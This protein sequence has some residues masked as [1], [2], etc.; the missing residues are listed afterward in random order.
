MNY[1][2]K[3]ISRLILCLMVLC[4][5]LP[6]RALAANAPDLS[7]K[8]DLTI[9][10]QYDTCPLTGAEFALWQVGELSG[11]GTLTLTG[12]YAHYPVDLN[13]LTAAQLNDAAATLYSYISLD[14]LPPQYTVATGEDGTV[15][16]ADIPWGV[17]LMYTPPIEDEEARL[18]YVTQPQLVILPHN[19]GSGW[20]Y[21][22]TVLPKCSPEPIEEVVELKVLKVWEDNNN[23][24]RPTSV[25]VHLLCDGAVYD[26]VTLSPEN[27]WRHSWEKLSAGRVWSVA[28]EVP[29]DYSVSITVEGNTFVVTNTGD[30]PPTPPPDIPQ[31]GLTWW[32]VPVLAF[33]GLVLIA[34]G[35]LVGRRR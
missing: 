14:S 23:P 4:L 15:M 11:E 30:Q 31:T 20:D 7:R 25:V 2:R 24:N 8:C 18:R 9:H 26:T 16:L 22:I 6:V 13:G 32:P 33:A 10:Y 19:T 5:S 21:A 28:E 3:I 29:E 35:I 17:Y 27:D 12:A 1:C 34:A